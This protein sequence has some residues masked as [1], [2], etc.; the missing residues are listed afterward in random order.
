MRFQQKCWLRSIMLD[1]PAI[2]IFGKLFNLFNLE[3]KNYCNPIICTSKYNQIPV[4][5]ADGGKI[6][7]S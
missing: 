4:R 1:R 6:R 2:K 5:R 7:I 3:I